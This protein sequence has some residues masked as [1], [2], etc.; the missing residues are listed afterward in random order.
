MSFST[1]IL[2]AIGLFS[3]GAAAFDWN[4][5]MEHRKASSV[6]RLLGSRNRGRA[7]Y[8]LLGCVLI[9][10]AFLRAFAIIAS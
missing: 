5:F 6:S 8:I 10:I 9:G 4:W 3:I 7:F 1:I 2:I